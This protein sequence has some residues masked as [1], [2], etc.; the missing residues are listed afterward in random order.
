MTY[1]LAHHDTAALAAAY[2]VRRRVRIHGLL[3]DAVPLAEHL[4]RREDWRQ[5]LNSGDKVFELDRATRAGMAPDRVATLDAA[6]HRGAAEGFQF[7]YESVRVPDDDDARRAAGDPLSEFAR[8]LSSGEM[9][10]FLRAVTGEEH[11]DFAD[12]QATRFVAGDFLT[13]HDDAVAGKHRRAAY[14]FGLTPRWRLEWGGLLM[15]HAGVDD[16]TGVVPA[17]NVLDVFA[18][19]QPHSVSLVSPAALDA[20]ISVTGWLRSTR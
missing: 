4:A 14:V 15:F 1:R 17:F 20:R 16:F 8:W 10:A 9:R 11:I 19:P 13:G 12:A 18:V 6:V 3:R 5:V 2:R 7:R